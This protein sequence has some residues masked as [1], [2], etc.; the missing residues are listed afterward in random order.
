MRLLLV[1]P[2]LTL[3]YFSVDMLES[4]GVVEVGEVGERMRDCFLFGEGSGRGY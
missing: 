1:Y 4:S 2:L 3:C